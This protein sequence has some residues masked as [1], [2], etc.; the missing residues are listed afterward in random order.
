MVSIKAMGERQ[1]EG[2]AAPIWS[3]SVSPS[4]LCP[5]DIKKRR[6]KRE[7]LGGKEQRVN[8]KTQRI[9]FKVSQNALSHFL[10]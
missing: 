3:R 1:A 7:E 9:F 4:P 8:A 6:N 5:E 10:S 2:L